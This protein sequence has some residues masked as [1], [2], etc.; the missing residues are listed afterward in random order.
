M[1]EVVGISFKK[2]GKVYYFAP[3]KYKLKSGI[4]VIVETEQGTQFGT[5]VEENKSLPSKNFNRDLK[6]VIRIATKNDYHKHLKNIED[7]KEALNAC[8]S[9]VEKYKLN[10]QVIEATYTFDRNQLVFR[11]ISDNRIDFRNLV[12]ELASLYKTRIELRQVGVRDR[13]KEIGGCGICG[14]KLCCSRFLT[15]LDA[16]SINMAKNQN[17]SLNPTKING[18]CG[19]LLCCLKYEDDTYSSYKF[20]LPTIGSRVT[21]KEGTGKVISVNIL[22]QTYKVE[23]PD[24]GIVEVVKNEDD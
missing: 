7:A 13:A 22:R 23:I 6:K 9:L 11:F 10:M 1:I 12:K 16:V 20:N 4:T 5:V 15:D 2:G 24:V 19:R 17:L 3:G 18:A 8:K 21:T 14:Q